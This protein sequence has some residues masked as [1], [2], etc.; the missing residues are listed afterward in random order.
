VDKL[1]KIG[2]EGVEKELSGRGLGA[3]LVA[4]LRGLL[5]LD[6]EADNHTTLAHLEA[7]LAGSE[8]GMRGVAQLRELLSLTAHSPVADFVKI[9]PFLAR[10]LS[11]YTG[12]IFEVKSPQ[13][14]GSIAAG[15][16]YDG[17]V[18][19]FLGRDVSAVGFSLGLERLEFVMQELGISPPDDDSG[20]Q[21]MVARFGDDTGETLKLATELRASGLRVDVFPETSRLGKQF[22]A[23]QRRGI[24]FVAL[25]GADEIADGVVAIKDLTTGEQ[26][27]VK[28]DGV[29]AAITG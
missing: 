25:L 9:S 7:S 3:D 18:G 8:R 15:G 20:P 22:K 26:T 11:Y 5:E 4:N 16:R 29:A 17:L 14:A 10:G 27:R 13:L 2:W 19:M 28:R 23:A 1:D 12:P 6:P 24:R 21:I